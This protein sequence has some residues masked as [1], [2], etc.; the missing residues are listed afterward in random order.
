VQENNDSNSS[1]ILVTLLLE[2]PARIDYP[3]L[4]ERIG[5]TLGI[6]PQ[7]V[8]QLTPDG[9]VM[10]VAGDDLVTGLNLDFPYPEDLS[11]LTACAHWWPTAK[12]DIARNKAHLSIG[13]SWSKFTRLDAHM[14]HMLL[15]RELLEQLPVIGVLWGSVLTP[16]ENFKGEFQAAMTGQLPILL[17]VLIQYSS[18]PNGNTL[19]STTGM[20]AFGHM[21]IE[22]ES[23]L[24]MQETY[25]IVRNIAS[26]IIGQDQSIAEGETIGMSEEQQ[27][28]VR[29]ERSFRADVTDKVYWLELTDAPTIERPS[30]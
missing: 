27:I 21:E 5:P 26:Y 28:K 15:V 19:I 11:Q 29:H 8:E 3:R 10:L 24:P 7:S 20:R 22:T 30:L 4:V 9:P 6:E 16:A 17:W 23:V 1:N 25:D 2:R 13:S 18:L 14:R 12:D